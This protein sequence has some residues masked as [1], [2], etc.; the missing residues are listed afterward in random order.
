MKSSIFKRSVIIA[1]HKTSVNVEQ[2]FWKSLKEIAA[3]RNMTV[4]VLVPKTEHERLWLSLLQWCARPYE[5]FDPTRFAVIEHQHRRLSAVRISQR[6]LV[7]CGDK[8]RAGH[9]STG[10]RAPP[11]TTS[12]SPCVPMAKL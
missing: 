6:D 2:E 11:A 1:G 5:I 4:G 9:L 8:E 10:Q 3:E 7:G 12:T